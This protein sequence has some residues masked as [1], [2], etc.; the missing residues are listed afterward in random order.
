MKDIVRAGNFG[1]GLY[2]STKSVSKPLHPFY[3]KPMFYYPIS[4]LMLA[5]IKDIVIISK[6]YVLA[7]FKRLLGNGQDYSILCK[8]PYW[9]GMSNNMYG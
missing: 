8:N 4:A 7:S 5:G 1:T 6:P 3:N 2:H 9:T